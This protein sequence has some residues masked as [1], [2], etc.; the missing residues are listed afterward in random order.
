MCVRGRR[1]EPD[2]C[3][4]PRFGHPLLF[5]SKF[6]PCFHSA[7]EDEQR[8]F[9]QGHGVQDLCCSSAAVLVQAL[10][11]PLSLRSR[12]SF[13]Q[14]SSVAAAAALRYGI[15][16]DMTLT[17]VL[18][19]ASGIEKLKVFLLKDSVIACFINRIVCRYL[20][21]LPNLHGRRVPMP[22]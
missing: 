20:P 14:F 17:G 8:K 2:R 4:Y 18:G 15:G 7:L 22:G 6:L 21:P 9:D 12:F 19:G 11:N 10:D 3:Q 1:L 16:R 5:A 13:S